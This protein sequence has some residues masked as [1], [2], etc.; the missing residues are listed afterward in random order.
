[1]ERADVRYR[2]VI[3]MDPAVPIEDVA[4]TVKE[5]IAEGKVLHFGLSEPAVAT[6]PPGACGA[7]G[8]GAAERIFLVVAGAGDE[9]HPRLRATSWASASCRSAR[10]A[11]A[12]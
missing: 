12:S 7:A 4:G 5:L 9:R 6:H 10:W 1:M 8:G 11:R 2:F 3:D